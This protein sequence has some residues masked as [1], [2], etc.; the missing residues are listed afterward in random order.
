MS[1]SLTLY[2]IKNKALELA[3]NE[4]TSEEEKAEL[5]KA[6]QEELLAKTEGIIAFTKKVEAIIEA[7]KSEEER[8]KAN[9]KSYE[10]KLE[11]FKEYVK[12]CMMDMNIQKIETALGEMKIS[13]NP[14]SVEIIDATKIPQEFWKEKTDISLD[15]KG[16]L[17][18]FKDTGEIIDGVK[19]QT[20]AYGL[21]IK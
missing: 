10:K 14:A 1:N 8:L 5:Q 6:V 4:E 9:R 20:N 15:K 21:R 12:S 18:H 17:D 19:I 3:M 11:N 7:I 16:I 13:K 2:E